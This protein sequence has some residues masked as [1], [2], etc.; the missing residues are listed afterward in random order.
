M[1]SLQKTILSLVSVLCVL[2]HFLSPPSWTFAHEFLF[3]FTYVPIVFSA[4]WVG[5]SF[6]LWLTILF[7]LAYV[8]HIFFQ[9]Y[10]HP[11]HHDV[12]SITLDLGL[13]FVVAWVAG[14]LSDHQRSTSE[15]L[16]IAYKDLREKTQALV[17]F[18]ERA[19]KT[20]RL[21]TMGELAGTVA[22]EI[23]TPLSGIQ[24]AV[25]IITSKNSSEDI[26]EKFSKTVFR[27]VERI[28]GVVEDFLKL[29]KEGKAEKE[30]F[31]L[32]FFVS[33]SMTLLEP[34]L[35]KKIFDLRIRSRKALKFLV[36][37]ISS[38][39]F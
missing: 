15:R 30:S 18:E 4:L 20:E 1:S 34:I 24:G 21:R 17:E 37:R 36:K 7:C 6:A 38:N 32:R 19:R 33:E 14:S 27:E 28:N 31:D 22:H 2:G 35:K 16:S 10:H 23:R 5:R 9:L 39:R 12:F 13:Y 8:F 29:G 25:E 11:A 3:K 26:K